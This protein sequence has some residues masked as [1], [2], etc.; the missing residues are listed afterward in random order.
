VQNENTHIFFNPCKMIAQTK[1]EA[2]QSISFIT[3][4]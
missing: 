2:N 4:Y 3:F 1:I